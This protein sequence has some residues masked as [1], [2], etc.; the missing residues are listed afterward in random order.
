MFRLPACLLALGGA[1]HEFS[2][3]QPAYAPFQAVSLLSRRHA[4]CTCDVF[5]SMQRTLLRK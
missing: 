2:G 5:A 3:C 4:P 1:V